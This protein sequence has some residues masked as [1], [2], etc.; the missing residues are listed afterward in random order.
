MPPEHLRFGGGAAETAINPLVAVYLLIAVLLILVLPRG[1]AI[2][3]FLFAFFTI[4]IGQVV[5]LGSLHFTALRILILAGLAR[6][7]GFRK[8]GSGGKFPGGF[9]AL[10]RVVVLWSLSTLIA[11]CLEF[12]DMAAWAN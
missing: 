4:P 12:R 9:N 6:R 2:T 5:V 8:S 11:F 10:D 3:P 7:A 1:K